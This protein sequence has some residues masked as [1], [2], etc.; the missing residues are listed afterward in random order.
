[1]IFTTRGG[2]EPD[3]GASGGVPPLRGGLPAPPRRAADDRRRHARCGGSSSRAR[4]PFEGKSTVV[5]NLGLAFGEVGKRVIIADAD[6]H[7]PTLHRIAE[8]RPTRKGFTDLLA[9]TGKSAR[10]DHADHRRRAARPARQ[11]ARPRLPADRASA[12]TGC[13]RSS[14]TCPTRPT[15]SCMDSSPILLIPDN[16]YMA[17][18]ADGIVLVVAVPARRGRGTCCAPR[19]ILERSGTPIVGRRPE[20]DAGEAPELVLQAVQRLLRRVIMSPNPLTKGD[21]SEPCRAIPCTRSSRRAR[22]R[23]SVVGLGYVGL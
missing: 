3:D 16:L 12:P 8:H 4:C 22:A 15:T 5:F 20:P 1:M 14:A 13:R 9:G 21:R 17:A 7:R 18:A 6:F 23:V 11:R 19:A 2:G 10:H